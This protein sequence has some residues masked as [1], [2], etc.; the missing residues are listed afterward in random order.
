MASLKEFLKAQKQVSPLIEGKDKLETSD[1]AGQVLTLKDF[2]LVGQPDGS[3][4]SVV[5][6]E[7]YPNNFLFGGSVLTQLL[8]KAVE[9]YDGSL[10][11]VREELGKEPIKFRIVSKKAKKPDAVTGM[12][13]TYNDIEFVD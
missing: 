4:Y 7:E 10:D 5:L 9:E 2:D 3:S 12:L 11:A 1:V 8:V 13:R 6:L